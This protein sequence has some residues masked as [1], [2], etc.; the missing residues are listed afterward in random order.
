M[1]TYSIT[2]PASWRRRLFWLLSA[3]LL[4]GSLI[5]QGCDPTPAHAQLLRVGV[6]ES[7]GLGEASLEPIASLDLTIF[8][9]R[10]WFTGLVLAART[11]EKV[12]GGTGHAYAWGSYIGKRF[13]RREIG[14]A[15]LRRRLEVEEYDVSAGHLLLWIGTQR[16]RTAEPWW[17]RVS[18][19]LP[20]S[21]ERKTRGAAFEVSWVPGAGDGKRL[22]TYASLETLW[23]DGAGPG[24]GFSYSAG[25]AVRLPS[26]KGKG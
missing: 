16:W 12:D 6:V 10:S 23:Y 18:A 24:S 1:Q 22:G 5:I 8:T 21:T 26:P 25:L 17:W 13:V 19:R 15:Y 3:E 20:D 14:A 4:I 11:A 9:R 2:R 7:S